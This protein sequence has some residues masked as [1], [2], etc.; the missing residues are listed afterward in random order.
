MYEPLPTTPD[1]PRD[2][3]VSGTDYCGNTGV[4]TFTAAIAVDQTPPVSRAS[5]PNTT[6]VGTDSFP[7]SFVASD[8][9]GCGV[10]S[11]NLMVR[12]PGA[13][14][15]SVIPGGDSMWGDS[16]TTWYSPSAGSGSYAFVSVS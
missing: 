1:G 2:I 16:G 12:E 9:A 6:L 4:T 8:G 13:T 11:T 15:Y 14:G 5:S 10:S 3:V 7:V